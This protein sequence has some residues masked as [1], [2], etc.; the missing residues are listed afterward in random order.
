[1]AQEDFDLHDRRLDRRRFLV[2]AALAAAAGSVFAAPAAQAAEAAGTVTAQPTEGNVNTWNVGLITAHIGRRVT[3]GENSLR[4]PADGELR[5]EI[6][7]RFG[8]LEV[9][10]RY[11]P[12]R[13]RL[14][15]VHSFSGQGR[16]IP[17]PSGIPA[18]G[19]TEI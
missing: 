8:V 17:A 16:A 9:R 4:Q 2:T 19:W 5:T 12:G 18:Q 13:S 11:V 7:G 1:M 15:N 14:K 6:R 10:G 3:P